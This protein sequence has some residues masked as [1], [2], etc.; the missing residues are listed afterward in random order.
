MAADDRREPLFERI[1]DRLFVGDGATA[2]FLIRHDWA[3]PVI[4]FGVC[5]AVTLLGVLSSVQGWSDVFVGTLIALGAVCAVFMI[6]MC[7]RMNRA[8]RG[9]LP[10]LDRVRRTARVILHAEDAD[11]GRTVLV[12]YLGADGVGHDAQLADIVHESSMQRFVP[13]S[14][15]QVR[16]FRDP[17]LADTVVF[18]AEAHDDVWR[19]GWRLDGVRI[20]GEG[21]ALKPAAGSPFLGDGSTWEFEP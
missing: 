20:G 16:A 8:T 3:M 5:G 19:D 17:D 21:G 18:L 15:W 4:G 10:A 14:T 13:G 1:V 9:P 2:P 7:V 6:A 12:E 11:A